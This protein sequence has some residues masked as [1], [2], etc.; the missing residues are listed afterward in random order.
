MRISLLIPTYKRSK[1][2]A[3]CLQSIAHQTKS[4]N[5]VVVVCRDEDWDTRTFLEGITDLRLP[6]HIVLVDV[7]GQV[8]ALNAGLAQV[9]SDIVA[10]TD[11]DAAPWPDWLSRIETHFSENPRLGGVGGRDHVIGYGPYREHK[12]VGIL[13]WFGR[14][15]GNHHCGKGEARRVDFLKGANMS[16]RM[17]ALGPLRFDQRLRGS[18]AQVHNDFAFSL[19]VRARGWQII[20]DPAVAVDH[21]PAQR[22]GN[23]ERFGDDIR[24]RSATN[25]SAYNETLAVLEYFPRYRHVFFWFWAIVAG[26]DE[27][28]GLLRCIVSPTARMRRRLL[29]ALGGRFEALAIARKRRSR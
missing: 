21:Y 6:L 9:S 1:D 11:D 5:E 26:T 2:L 16:Y 12:T 18:G 23:D 4:P 14:R 29:S 17:A 27:L 19:E 13:Q 25:A 20:Y 10:I 28:P 7:P 24:S 22:F 15:I 8:A 3:R